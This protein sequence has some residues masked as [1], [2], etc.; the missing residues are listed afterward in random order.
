M[1]V[2]PY[3]WLPYV[4][5][6]GFHDGMTLPFPLQFNPVRVGFAWQPG[7]GGPGAPGATSAA[8]PA[9]TFTATAS[10]SSLPAANGLTEVW[11]R[12]VLNLGVRPNALVGLMRRKLEEL[13]GVVLERASLEGVA[14]VYLLYISK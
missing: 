3:P 1:H 11:T 14:V 2:R 10:G 12:D 8:V 7:G 6:P 13:G 4:Y 5:R 9:T